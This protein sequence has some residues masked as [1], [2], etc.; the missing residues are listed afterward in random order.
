MAKKKK[1]SKRTAFVPTVVFGTAVLGVVPACVVGCGGGES[2]S[3]VSSDGSPGDASRDALSR[4]DATSPSDAG[5]PNDSASS[6]D[7]VLL[8]VGYCAFCVAAVGFDADV[9]AGPEA[10]SD[11]GDNG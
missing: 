10:G 8:G 5:S 1:R 11:S 2:S 7:Y 3:D 6:P 4:S 9:D